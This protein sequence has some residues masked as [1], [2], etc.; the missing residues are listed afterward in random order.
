MRNN[1]RRHIALLLTVTT[2]ATL[3]GCGGIKVEIS[4]NNNKNTDKP[5]EITVTPDKET[6]IEVQETPEVT[7][8]VTPKVLRFSEVKDP[9]TLENP[10]E[11]TLAVIRNLYTK[12]YSALPTYIFDKEYYVTTEDL[13]LTLPDKFSDLLDSLKGD[14]DNYEV[15]CEFI[16]DSNTGYVTFMDT[17]TGNAIKTVSIELC[18]TSNNTY[19]WDVEDKIT[20]DGWK[21]AIPMNCKLV[22]EGKEVPNTNTDRYANDLNR[23]IYT[24]NN[25]GKYSK[26][27]TVSC[28]NF[29][30]DLTMMPKTY[31]VNAPEL[32]L[33]DERIESAMNYT[34]Q[35]WQELMTAHE[36]GDLTE[37]FIKENYTHAESEAILID[38]I[39]TTFNG[40]DV[41][42]SGPDRCTDIK[43]ISTV[44]NYGK[45]SYWKSNNRLVL[46]LGMESTFNNYFRGAGSDK[47]YT[48]VEL[49]VDGDTYKLADI[50]RWMFTLNYTEKDF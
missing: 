19:H 1:F 20:I 28:E 40:L 17:E 6:N 18:K 42:N 23:E 35:M 15:E 41:L 29:S 43:L 44:Q 37:D 26:N 36:N 21:I 38:D 22:V 45:T 46:Y 11:V 4:T 34:A 7:E 2:M 50:D 32:P 49:I 14:L 39:L 5:I 3:A 48:E 13:E 10:T 8:E 30:V 27:V 9:E 25:V 47:K 16:E 33:S 12:N 24:L 31:N